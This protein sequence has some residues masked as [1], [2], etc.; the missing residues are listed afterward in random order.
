MGSILQILA[1][2]QGMFILGLVADAI[3]ICIRYGVKEE[4]LAWYLL[5]LIVGLSAIMI[6]TLRNVYNHFYDDSLLWQ[7]L[8]IVG[9]T[10]VD[11]AFLMKFRKIVKSE[12]KNK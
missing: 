2:C 8:L 5:L 12:I 7:L 4:H 11:I 1:A 6:C 9:Y 10:C 3:F